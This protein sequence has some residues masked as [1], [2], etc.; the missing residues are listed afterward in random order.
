MV[1]ATLDPAKN[2]HG[3]DIKYFRTRLEAEKQAA[4]Y[5]AAWWKTVEVK[6]KTALAVGGHTYKTVNCC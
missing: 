1:V 5:T 3:N 6:E 2:A 4:S